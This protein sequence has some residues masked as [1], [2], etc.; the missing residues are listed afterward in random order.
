MTKKAAPL[1][2]HEV[3]KC[4]NC[5]CTGTPAQMLASRPRIRKPASQ[6]QSR[7]AGNKGGRPVK[8]PANE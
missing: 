8:E 5:K 1:C 3:C 2:N 4:T 6:E 7:T